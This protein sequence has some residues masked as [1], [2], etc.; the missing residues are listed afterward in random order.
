MLFYIILLHADDHRH[1]SHHQR[2]LGLE[3]YSFPFALYGDLRIK[4]IR[5]GKFLSRRILGI[6]IPITLLTT[7]YLP[8][9]ATFTIKS[10]NHSLGT[11]SLPLSFPAAS[12][13]TTRGSR[14]IV[15][16]GQEVDPARTLRLLAA[17]ISQTDC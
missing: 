17:L 16:D 11:I 14:D 5:T 1:C 13:E 12:R 2:P 7:F 3:M 8:P 6:E 15:P 4:K 9:S 10:H